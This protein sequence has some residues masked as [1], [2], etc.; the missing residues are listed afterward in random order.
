MALLAGVGASDVIHGPCRI[1]V[2]VFPGC[3]EPTIL[4]ALEVLRIGLARGWISRGNRRRPSP[5]AAP[6]HRR[7]DAAI[8][9]D[10][11]DQR[12]TLLAK[13]WIPAVRGGVAV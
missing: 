2:G 11:A 3:A 10:A 9:I 7:L 12:Q 6:N 1:A 4:A 5:E 8:A 13:P